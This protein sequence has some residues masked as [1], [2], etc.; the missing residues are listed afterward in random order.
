M[1]PHCVQVC[2]V[3]K[4]GGLAGPKTLE[5]LV[6]VVLSLE[7]GPGAAGQLRMLRA[8]KNRH[9][10]QGNGVVLLCWG[11]GGLC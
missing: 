3:N 11:E 6:D 7:G 8:L 9:G 5:H 1:P 10:R 4:S 2:Q